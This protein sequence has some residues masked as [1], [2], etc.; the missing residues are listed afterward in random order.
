MEKIW[1][2]TFYNELL[3]APKEYPVLLTQVPLNPKAN[4]EK[5]T[6]IIFE[7]FN[8]KAMYMAIQAVLSLYASGCTTD[9]VMDSGD[10][11]HPHYAQ[12]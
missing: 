5:M 3:V 9:I 12:Q 4:H 2:H 6:Q 7:T 1:H 8:T 11:G 10:G